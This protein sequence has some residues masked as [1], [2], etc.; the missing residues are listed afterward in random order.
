MVNGVAVDS[1][2]KVL[3]WS[4]F[5]PVPVVPSKNWNNCWLAKNIGNQADCYNYMLSS[6]LSLLI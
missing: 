5:E 4:G 6:L 3:V 1:T 2:R